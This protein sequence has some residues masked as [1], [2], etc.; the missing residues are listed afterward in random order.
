M[1]KMK[2]DIQKF[3]NGSFEFND[4]DGS[5]RGKIEWNSTADNAHILSRN[6]GPRIG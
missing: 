4:W 5:I 3:A 6:R 1:K 2:L